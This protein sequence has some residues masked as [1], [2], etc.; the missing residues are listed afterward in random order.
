MQQQEQNP[1]SAEVNSTTAP[2]TTAP[3]RLFLG[4]LQ[5]QIPSFVKSVPFLALIMTL[6]T[7]GVGVL[8]VALLLKL[9]SLPNC[10]DLFIPTA[11][12]GIRLYCAELVAKKQTLKDLTKAIEL[13]NTLPMDHPL[14]NQI[15]LNIENWAEEIL[16]IAD[17]EYQAGKL[18][19][20]IAIA[21]KIPQNVPAYKLVTKQVEK[22]QETWK[23]AEE[24]YQEAENNL[25]ES[26][27][28]Q[29]YSSALKLTEINNKYWSVTKYDQLVA[30]ISMGKEDSSKLDRAY[31]LKRSTDIDDLGEAIKI[32]QQI[33]SASYAYTEAQNLI[34][35]CAKKLVEI[36]ERRLKNKDWNSALNITKK[37]PEI[38][39]LK[40]IIQDIND[41]ATALSKAEDGSVKGIQAAIAIAQTI[42]I[43]RPYHDQAQDLIARW[44]KEIQGVVQLEKAKEIAKGGSIPQLTAA[45]SEA[46]LVPNS[47]PLYQ[48]AQTEIR[49]WDNQIQT[50]EDR[51]YLDKAEE[52]SKLG[53]ITSLQAAIDQAKQIKN[54]RT[55]SREA[56]IKIDQWSRKIQNI[57]DQPI[58]E[59]SQGLANS[60][61]INTAIQIAQQIKPNRVLYQE[62]QTKIRDWR[63]EIQAQSNLKQAYKNA[64]MG[65]VES[66]KNAIYLAKQAARYNAVKNEAKEGVNRWSYQLLTLAQQR[67]GASV[68]DAITI[69]KNIPSDSDAYEAAKAQLEQ[70]ETSLQPPAVPA[71]PELP[72][73][74]ENQPVENVS[75]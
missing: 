68:L 53:D 23:K 54:G 30:K 6:T 65:T 31:R 14:R 40:I 48:K 45:I 38:A 26:K 71:V 57:E 3:S 34:K 20:A 67:A 72:P 25:K 33:T 52:L 2:T 62:A 39:E 70:W 66:L 51:P 21:N 44:T 36:A 56:R 46:K 12:A 64:E 11:T 1:I 55:L 42:E 49:Q 28:I 15:N 9:P 22:W 13:V 63:G 41:I 60:G 7:G 32:A 50:I 8:G 58:L 18:K 10:P 74:G 4:K 5:L 59:Q 47:N 69:A 29:A 24:Y 73:T 37:I 43:G 19:E 17:N 61:N 35:D 16:K 75:Q 27:W